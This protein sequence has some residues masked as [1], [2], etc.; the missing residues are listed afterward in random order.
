MTGRDQES[1]TQASEERQ[2]ENSEDNSLAAPDN[3]GSPDDNEITQ[4]ILFR[5]LSNPWNLKHC[6][7]LTLILSLSTPIVIIAFAHRMKDGVTRVGS[8]MA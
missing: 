3:P 6:A 4:N 8:N 1:R 7:M 2:R 5:D